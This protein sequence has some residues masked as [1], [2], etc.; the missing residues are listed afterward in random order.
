M[1]PQSKK[2]IFKL[3]IQAV[4]QNVFMTY[5]IFKCDVWQDDQGVRAAE[6]QLLSVDTLLS[7]FILDPE[8][9]PV[10]TRKIQV[11]TGTYSCTTERDIYEEM[12]ALLS[13]S[14]P[15]IF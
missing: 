6:S 4:T 15:D 12:S 7:S 2:C 5:L 9:C 14:Y 13:V 11:R 8:L 3:N 10:R 1:L